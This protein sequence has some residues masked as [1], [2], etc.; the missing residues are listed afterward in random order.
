MFPAIR[1]K[2]LTSGQRAL[3]FLGGMRVK[4]MRLREPLFIADIIK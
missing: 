4:K 1:G 2:D 3:Q